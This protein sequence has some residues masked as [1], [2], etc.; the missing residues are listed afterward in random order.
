MELFCPRNFAEL[1]HIE[2]LDYHTVVYRLP[3]LISTEINCERSLVH[4]S[5]AIFVMSSFKYIIYEVHWNRA[6]L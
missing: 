4:F 2:I 5:S 3:T 1:I 6:N